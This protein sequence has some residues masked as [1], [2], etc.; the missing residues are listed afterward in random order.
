MYLIDW[1]KKILDFRKNTTFDRIT[2]IYN[3][4]NKNQD[5]KVAGQ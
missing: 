5:E 2:T 4:C 3:D 1:D